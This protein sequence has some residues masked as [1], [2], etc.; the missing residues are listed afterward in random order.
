MNVNVSNDIYNMFSELFFL[1]IKEKDLFNKDPEIYLKNTPFFLGR[2]LNPSSKEE[3]DKINEKK[4][5]GILV[6]NQLIRNE[7]TIDITKKISE[8]FIRSNQLCFLPEEGESLIDLIVFNFFNEIVALKNFPDE[9]KQK[10]ILKFIANEQ[11][12][13]IKSDFQKYEFRFPVYILG[14]NEDIKLYDSVSL[15]KEA[16]FS[17]EHKELKKYM[18]SRTFEPNY[19]IQILS[20][21]K[22]SYKYSTSK[23][24]RAKEATI[25]ILL[26]LYGSAFGDITTNGL[27]INDDDKKPHYMKFHRSGRRG[28]KLEDSRYYSYSHDKNNCEK[29]W[30]MLQKD[31]DKQKKF[32]NILFN[33][34]DKIINNNNFEK[35]VGSLLERSLKWFG[36]AIDEDNYENKIVKL[37]I[38]IE[39]LVNFKS[40]SKTNDTDSERF[41]EIF[42]RR[43]C[44]INANQENVKEKATILYKARSTIAHGSSLKVKLNFDIVSFAAVTI[45]FAI[46]LFSKFKKCGI[47]EIGFQKTLPSFIDKHMI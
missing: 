21:I 14:L 28:E 29:F 17:L 20:N 33:I 26:I 44:V 32:Y 7:K 35:S 37:T 23:A 12:I 10:N 43:V 2:T 46:Q 8:R 13:K 39:S 15:V 3:F 45:L 5:R 42:V 41:T 40:D 9:D 38:A 22:A 4:S 31:F 1:Y 25:N 30:D 6:C 36:D 24:I 47:D 18:H 16:D 27:F 11:L 19:S 34:S